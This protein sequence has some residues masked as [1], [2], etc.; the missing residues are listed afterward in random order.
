VKYAALVYQIGKLEKQFES[1]YPPKLHVW[2][3]GSHG[4]FIDSWINKRPT[5]QTVN[6]KDWWRGKDDGGRYSRKDEARKLKEAKANIKA[7]TPPAD[8]QEELSQIAA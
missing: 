5:E 3:D 6:T 1:L 2:F 8:E 7:L 4:Y